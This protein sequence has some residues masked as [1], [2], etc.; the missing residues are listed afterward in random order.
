[1]MH[2]KTTDKTKNMPENGSHIQGQLSAR[3]PSQGYQPLKSARSVEFS[4]VSNEIKGVHPNETRQHG[5]Q[6]AAQ[7]ERTSS[8]DSPRSSSSTT[9]KAGQ[10]LSSEIRKKE[11]QKSM[12]GGTYHI[13][14]PNSEKANVQSRS[15]AA[16]KRDDRGPINVYTSSPSVQNPNAKASTTSN[17]SETVSIL[18]GPNKPASDELRPS[19]ASSSSSSSTSQGAHGPR[20]SSRMIPRSTKTPGTGTSSGPETLQT[21]T[22]I[23]VPGLALTKIGD[24]Y[25]D[26]AEACFKP[27]Q[28]ASNNEACIKFDRH[29]NGN[30]SDPGR[31]DDNSHENNSTRDIH[32]NH[33][34]NHNNNSS[35]NENI[36]LSNYNKNMTQPQASTTHQNYAQDPTSPVNFSAAPPQALQK[37]T[38]VRPSTAHVYTRSL[39]Q[40]DAVGPQ[41]AAS[42]TGARGMYDR[43]DTGHMHGAESVPN[44]LGKLLDINRT[45]GYSTERVMYKEFE[46][47]ASMRQSDGSVRIVAYYDQSILPCEYCMCACVLV[48][49]CVCTYV[50]LY[51]YICMFFTSIL[52]IFMCML[53]TYISRCAHTSLLYTCVC[54]C[55]GNAWRLWDR[56]TGM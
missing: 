15:S 10:A 46:R 33:N 47:M 14:G 49:V 24:R 56:A 34:N 2:A 48:C 12:G 7:R 26:E 13:E 55:V 44:S 38:V 22:K 1:M 18:S 41:R 5:D 4:G 27:V 23:M 39:R 32:E 31:D 6:A 3:G 43:L 8:S 11:M 45:K 29:G 51:V 17:T 54:M 30:G 21:R 20:I 50:C 40:T 42:F 28:S 52:C 53:C 9:E 16:V 36:N 19:H 35:N 37:P 25:V